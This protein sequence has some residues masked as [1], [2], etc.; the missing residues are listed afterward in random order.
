MSPRM[1]YQ[2]CA[3]WCHVC[4]PQSCMSSCHHHRKELKNESSYV[5]SLY[6]S[7]LVKQETKPIPVGWRWGQLRRVPNP[8]CKTC[9][10]G[11]SQYQGF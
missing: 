10:H 6:K 7:Y 4:V 8:W 9:L 5:R 1:G 2:A 3:I 11:S